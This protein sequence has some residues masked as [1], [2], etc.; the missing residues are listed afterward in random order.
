MLSVDGVSTS[1]TPIG[2]PS[3][4]V[5][6][7]VTKVVLPN[8][9]DVNLDSPGPTLVVKKSIDPDQKSE[10]WLFLIPE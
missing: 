8:V 2:T 10:E 3:I 1:D 7:Q 9:I 4:L 5:V 6:R